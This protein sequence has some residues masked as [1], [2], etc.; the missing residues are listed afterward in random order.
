M[1]TWLS[2]Q[3]QT[4]IIWA[5]T[6]VLGLT[7]PF[8]LYRHSDFFGWSAPRGGESITIGIVLAALGLLF[9][10][11]RKSPSKFVAA[12]T[13][14]LGFVVGFLSPWVQYEP[15]WAR[16]DVVTPESLWK[17]KRVAHAGGA[18]MGMDY[19]N[20]F[21]A[22]E[23]NKDF[24]DYFEIDFVLT[25]DG[26]LVCLH[27]WDEPDHSRMFGEVL[28]SPV[29][30]A[31]FR[32]LNRNGDLT[33]CDA[34]SLFLWLQE[35][36]GKYI[37]TDIKEPNNVEILDALRQAKPMFSER[38]IPQA[39]NFGEV[40]E[41]AEI[42]FEKV[43][44]TT[45]RMGPLEQEEFLELA[46]ESKPFAITMSSG[47]AGELSAELTRLGIPT[48]VFTVNDHKWFAKL[49]T[50]GISNVYTDTLSDTID[51]Y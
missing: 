38:L 41:L 50:F 37:V 49:R 51:G 32:R 35:N 21:E 11:T 28:E 46:S 47:Q 16:S 26:E 44:L 4:I 27:G 2:K 48:Y 15:F 20:S 13:L 8:L 34:E 22:L 18:F 9:F 19:T 36:P 10:L 40:K 17:V 39:Y 6:F 7:T 31:E 5:F 42:G 45:Y 29:S 24:F 30:L 25:T 14:S 43:I 23:A 12:A 3:W 33:A 1:R